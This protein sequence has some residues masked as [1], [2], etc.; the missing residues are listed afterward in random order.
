[1]SLS[2][3]I[4]VNTSLGFLAKT[5]SYGFLGD[6]YCKYLF[7]EFSW[8]ISSCWDV[9]YEFSLTGAYYVLPGFCRL[10]L[11]LFVSYE[12]D[13][14]CCYW[15]LIGSFLGCEGP[16]TRTMIVLL[17]F[18]SSGGK[19]FEF[20]GEVYNLDCCLNLVDHGNNSWHVL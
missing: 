2:E 13:S 3:M 7:S 12:K 4:I 6:D 14:L 11:E 10:L 5:A 17:D 9:C 16:W 8:L 20:S 15:R 1:M 18:L 19:Y